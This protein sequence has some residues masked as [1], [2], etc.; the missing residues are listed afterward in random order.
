MGSKRLALRLIVVQDSNFSSNEL[1]DPDGCAV[2]E[3]NVPECFDFHQR[4]S[5]YPANPAL[6][7][8]LCQMF[9]V[10]GTRQHRGIVA[11]PDMRVL[12]RLGSDA[13][14]TLLLKDAWE[15]RIV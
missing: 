15:P 13:V 1:S 4:V 7:L 12:V 3:A 10:V 11:F 8:R 2:I 5:G 9:G 14:Q 6:L